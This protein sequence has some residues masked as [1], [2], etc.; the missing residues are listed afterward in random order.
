M[1]NKIICIACPMGCHLTVT[2]DS[3]AEGGYRVE[4]NKCKRGGVYGVKEMTAP[5]RTLTTTVKIKGAALTRV[6][7]V[8][9]GEIPKGKLFEAMKVIAN[10][11]LAAPVSIG[12]IVVPNLVDSGVDLVIARSM[13]NINK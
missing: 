2:S 1:E 7:V 3:N 11:E 12:D 5:S 9:K 6:P 8:T 4:G 13:G 10:I